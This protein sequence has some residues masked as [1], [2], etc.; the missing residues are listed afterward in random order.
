MKRIL[1]TTA[2][3]LLATLCLATDSDRH[4]RIAKNIDLFSEVYRTLVNRY[5]DGAEP[6]GLM[7]LGLDSLFLSLDPYT[8]FISEADM[9][10]FRY[11]ENPSRVGNIGAQLVMRDGA[12]MIKE[13][14][15]SFAADKA[16]LRPG[17]YLLEIDGNPIKGL[18]L[19]EVEALARGAISD[20]T[21]FTFRRYGE[22]ETRTATLTLGEVNPKN[23]PYS[24]MLGESGAG[25]IVLTT[26]TQNAADNISKA[27]QALKNDHGAKGLV[28]DLR[29]NGGGLLHEAVSIVNLFVER[30]REVVSI[31]GKVPEGDKTFTTSNAPL[32]TGIPV[33][34]L[35]NDHS[36]SAS[37][38]VSGALQD[39]DRA[40]IV[41]QKSFGKGLVQNVFDIAF[42][43]K[44]KVTTAKYYVPSGRC[45][46]AARYVQGKP[47][48]IPE[49]E[50]KPFKTA[51]GRTVL[52]GGGVIPD[53][54]LE[55]K[56]N[57]A[58]VQALLDQFLI[59]DFA[60]EY[61]LRVDSIPP[62]G[63]FSFT[64]KDFEDFKKFVEKRSF[65]Y[66]SASVQA[67][68]ALEKTAREE[69]YGPALSASVQKLRDRF[70]REKAQ[71]FVKHREAVI[72]ELEIEIVS[73]YHYERGRAEIRLRRDPEV[74]RAVAL[75]Q[76]PS[77]MTRLLSPR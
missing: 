64:E 74:Q 5:V 66:A 62:A 52:D 21:T 42:N 19:E 13:V 57:P 55:K 23:V 58:F 53:L 77:E 18:A 73:R 17:D 75:L 22:T 38:I 1:R 41:G 56:S 49:S 60:T 33:A 72:R 4:H 40:V 26:F 67:L 11:L 7:R 30:G 59:F 32:D 69:G 15:E 31:R 70:E 2:F 48:E 24:G 12:V 36:A 8:N 47:V 54:K 45:I 76:N 63:V 16:G 34:V 71:D 43:C 44:I 46:Q 27:L 37:E 20:K 50:W 25:Y 9:E 35:V 6:S 51:G 65:R 39:L 14:Y 29:D 28:L 3:V 10:R 68:E 61:R